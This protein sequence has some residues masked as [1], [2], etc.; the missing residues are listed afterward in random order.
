MRN[1][2]I[3][4]DG[5]RTAVVL[6]GLLLL[7]PSASTGSW[8]RS[9]DPVE[10]EHDSAF[11][12]VI[13]SAG[14]AYSAGRIL[15]SGGFWKFVVI[16]SSES[17]GSEVWRYELAAAGEYGEARALALDGAGGL[18]VAGRIIAVGPNVFVMAKIDTTTGAEIW[19]EDTTASDP[20]VQDL[21]LDSLGNV[22]AVGEFGSAEFSVVKRSGTTGAE[23]RHEVRPLLERG[24]V[25]LI[26]LAKFTPYIAGPSLTLADFVAMFHF[27]PVSIA[28]KAIYGLDVLDGL[29]ATRR[30][31]KLMNMRPSVQ[32]ARREQLAGRDGFMRH[33]N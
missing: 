6:L 12:V 19:R 18:Y 13:D 5:R 25:A 26:R 11:D 1:K 20:Q 2:P 8:L 32:Q 27:P 22:I 21:V 23:T 17:D 10:V 30:H 14:D 33:A 9:V 3:S 31:T 28:S 7:I 16:K 29:A 15:D 24:L 4:V